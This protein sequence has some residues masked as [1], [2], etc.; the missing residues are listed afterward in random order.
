MEVWRFRVAVGA[1]SGRHSWWLVT[2]RGQRLAQAGDTFA[3]ADAAR[4]AC[5]HF[6]DGVAQWRFEVFEDATGAQR[7]RVHDGGVVIARSG[8]SFPNKTGAVNAAHEV[9]HH[10]KYAFEP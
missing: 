6:R 10:A 9:R 5:M 4:S 1:K 3:S 2:D 7:W 8:T